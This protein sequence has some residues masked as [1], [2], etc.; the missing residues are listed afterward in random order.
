MFV[1]FTP[2]A[3]K[4]ALKLMRAKTKE[5]NWRNRSNLSLDD[6]ATRYNPVLQ[7]W[8]NYY[9]RYQRSAL[10]PVW[11]HFNKTLVAWAMNKY[12]PLRGHK[13]RAAKFLQG[14]LEEQPNLFTHWRS[15]MKATFA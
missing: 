8:L 7:G 13:I 14:V 10:Y 9:G 12:K 3:S 11:R 6:I 1:S 4:D 15:G 5:C 2:A